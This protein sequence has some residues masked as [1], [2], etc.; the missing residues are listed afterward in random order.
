[1]ATY[2]RDSPRYTAA[3]EVVAGRTVDNLLVTGDRDLVQRELTTTAAITWYALHSPPPIE[4]DDVLQGITVRFLLAA[5][6][7]ND[8]DWRKFKNGPLRLL[9]G[10]DELL[11]EVGSRPCDA[12]LRQSVQVLELTAGRT[13]PAALPTSAAGTTRC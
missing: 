12:L 5:K 4:K 8:N 2:Y 13:Q 11:G 1:V 3:L 9:E 6:V 7:A 10:V